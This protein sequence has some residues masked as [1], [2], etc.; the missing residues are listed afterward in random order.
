MDLKA[1]REMGRIAGPKQFQQHNHRVLK[2]KQGIYNIMPGCMRYVTWNDALQ[3]TILCQDGGKIWQCSVEMARFLAQQVQRSPNL[4]K[5]TQC[6]RVTKCDRLHICPGLNLMHACV[7][8]CEC[9]QGESERE[10][11]GGGGERANVLC[12][13][14]PQH[15]IA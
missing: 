15:N 10:R 9:V 7:C 12:D 8:V 5:V 11:Q 3:Y 14:Q 4:F 1:K 2:I 6:L 13:M